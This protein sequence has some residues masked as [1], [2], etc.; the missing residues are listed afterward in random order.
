MDDLHSPQMQ[1][2]R[3]EV[4]TFVAEHLPEPIKQRT[5]QG[6]HVSKADMRDW[7]AILHRRGWSAPHWPEN[8]GG[9]GWS[10][11]KRM[12]FEIEL[13][14]GWAPAPSP[15]GLH[16][17]GPVIYTFGTDQQKQ[18]Y[19]PGILDGSEFWCQ[20]Y[21]EPNAG[22]D[23]AS[24][25]TAAKRQGDE[26]L[27][28]GQKIWTSQAQF[29]DMIFCLV[30]TDTSGSKQSGISMLLIDMSSPGVTVKPIITQDS[31]H[32]LNEV[33]FEDVRVPACNLIGEE[34]AG[35]RYAKFLLENE[36]TAS[37]YLPQAKQDMQRLRELIDDQQGEQGPL[38][39][40]PVLDAECAAL[41]I[42]LAA[43]EMTIYRIL[44]DNARSNSAAAAS[45]IKIKGAELQQRISALWIE[46]LGV[47]GLPLFTPG[48]EADYG[49]PGAVGA[50]SQFLIRRAVSIY[51]GTNE[52]QHGIIAKRGLHL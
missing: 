28:N 52:I 49:A 42:E 12:V 23:L 33:F 34:N 3:D 32:Y 6:F 45:M 17:I 18:R 8:H 22:S 13:A 2:F 47:H 48:A 7:T 10:P 20:G 4:R 43:H 46:A 50:M 25:R 11:L 14:Q 15:F 1:A 24:L 5:R 39:E 35:W 21:S 27:V 51:G 30:R 41:E 37:A 16:L 29:A 26:Y 38:A 19:L 40:E 44:T 31:S 9:T 36:R